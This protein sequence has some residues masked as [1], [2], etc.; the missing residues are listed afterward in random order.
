MWNRW[1]NGKCKESKKPECEDDMITMRGTY[2]KKRKISDE[3][4]NAKAY[5]M[6][7]IGSQEM[8]RLWNLKT[9]RKFKTPDLVKYI[10]IPPEKQAEHF[11]DPNY[12]FRV[13]RL[14]RKSPHFFIPTSATIQS[15]DG[16]LR[17]ATKNYG[18]SNQASTNSNNDSNSAT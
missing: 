13:L 5:N 9:N 6:H 16:Y 10:E 3:L 4:S 2:H 18:N 12:S 17:E 15:L 1:K 8:S 11:K 14:L 7:V